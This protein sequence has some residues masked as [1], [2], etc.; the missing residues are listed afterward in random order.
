[1]PPSLQRA[2]AGRVIPAQYPGEMEMAKILK[3][4]AHYAPPSIRVHNT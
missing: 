3:K 1:M 2:G 4:F